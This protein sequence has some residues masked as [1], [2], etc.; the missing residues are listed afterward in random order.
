MKNSDDRRLLEHK[1]KV[2]AERRAA[3]IDRRRQDTL[4]RT[5]PGVATPATVMRQ[6]E[7]ARLRKAGVTP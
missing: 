2:D 5:T 6:M 1:W 7:R 4:R 3:A